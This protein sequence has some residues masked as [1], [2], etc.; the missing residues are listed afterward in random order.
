MT[1]DQIEDIYELSPLQQGFLFH[2]VYLPAEGAYFEQ[3]IWTL[4]GD[5]DIAAFEQAWQDAVA[6]HPILRSS[7]HWQ[8]L[9]NPVQ[10][11]H[12]EVTLPIERLDWRDLPPS[13][14][15]DRLEALLAADR[16]QGFDLEQPPLMRV[17]LAQLAARSWYFVWSYHHLLLDGWSMSVLL[18]DVFRSYDALSHGRTIALPPVRPYGDYIE[19]LQQRDPVATEAFWRQTLA[20]FAAP[21]PLI[22]GQPDA[23]ASDPAERYQEQQVRLSTTTTA[24]LQ[25]LARQQ[26][27]TLNTIFQGAWALLLG[28]YS[29]EHDIVF[30]ATASGRPSDLPGFES[31]VGLFI[32]TLPVRVQT[33]PDEALLPWLR[34]L[35]AVQFELRQYEYSPL[36]QVQSWSDVPHS[37][38]LFESIVVFENHPVDRALQTLSRDLDIDFVRC[39]QRTS[40]PLTVMAVPGSEL[41]IRLSYDTQRFDAATITRLLGHLETLLE[42]MTTHQEQ[43][44]GKLALVTPAEERALLAWNATQAAYPT[45]TPIHELFAAQAARTPD[46]IALIFEQERL[47]YRALNERANRLAHYLQALGVGGCPQGET[48]VAL[49]AERS[50]DSVIG[51]L[52]IFKA[53]GCYVPLDPAYPQERL[54]FMLDDT[55]APVLLTQAR[56]LSPESTRLPEHHARVVCLDR[57]WAEI[58]SYSADDPQIAVRG[59]DLAYM[60]YTSGTTGR[61]KAVM[62]EHRHL[63]NTMLAGQETCGFTAAT[64]MPCIASFAFDISLFE[65]W[66]PLLVGGTTVLVTR[67]RALDLP[68]FARILRGTTALHALPSLMREIVDFARQRAEPYAE[69]RQVLVGGDLVPVDLV[70]DMQACFPAAQIFIAYGPTEGTILCAMHVVPGEQQIQ[71]HLIGT[72]LPNTILRIYDPQ[73]NLVPIGVAGELY[74]GGA[75]VARGYLNRPELTAE[76]FVTLDGQRWYRTGDLVRYLPDGT[77]EFLGRIDQQVKLRGFRI[78]LGEI[79][80]ALRQHPGIREAAVIARED[81]P[82][83]KR[84]VAYVVPS[85]AQ[86][87]GGALWARVA[88]TSSSPSPM[89]WEQGPEGEGLHSELETRS[90][91]STARSDAIELWPSI[92]EY[93]IYDE[94]LYYGLTNDTRRIAGYKAA[95]ERT[96]RDKVVVEIGTGK[97]AIVAQHCVAAGARRVYALEILEEPYRA[98][99]ERI[100]ALGLDDRVIVIHGDATTIELPEPAD[101]CVSEIFEAIGGGEGASEILNRSRRLLKPGGTMIPARSL[102]KIAAVCLPE[103]LAA[104][105]RFTGV[106]GYYVEQIFE[107]VGH[108]F[109][110]RLCIKNFPRSQIIS[111]EGVFEDLDFSDYTASEYCHNLSLTIDRAGRFDG[112]LIWLNLHMIEGVVLDALDHDYAWFPVYFPIFDPGVAVEPGDRIELICSASLSANGIHPDYAVEGRLLRRDGTPLPFAYQSVHHEQ[113]Y[114]ATPFYQRLFREDTIP[115]QP[116][117]QRDDL[118]AGARDHLKARLPEYMVPSAFVLLDTLPLTANGKVDRKALPAPEAAHARATETAITPRTPIEHKIAQIWQEVLQ[119]DGVGVNENFFDLGGH[120]I[121]MMQVHSKL[122]ERLNRDIAMTDLFRHPTIAALAQFLNPEVDESAAQEQA[123]AP[124]P[125]RAPIAPIADTAIAIVGMSGRFPGARDV[126]RFWQNLCAGSESITFFTDDELLAAG[127]DPALLSHPDYVK[128]GAI[129]DD[130]ELFDAGFFGYSPREAAIMDP[131]H[132]VFLECAWEALERAGYNPDAYEGGIGVFAGVSTNSYLLFNLYANR[133]LLES[134]GG[135]QTMLLNEKDHL[136][137]RVSYKLNL[138][139]PSVNLQTACSTSLVATVI[140]CQ[141]L[142][143]RQCDMALAGGVSINVPHTAGYR[144]QPGGIQSPDGH[145]RAFDADAQGTITGNGVGIVV[146]KRLHDALADGDQIQAVIKGFALNNDG[147]QKVGYTAPSVDG[148]AA[149]IEEALAMAGVAPETISYIETHGTGTPLGDPIEIAALSRVFGPV[150]K[151][152]QRCALGSVKTNIGHLDA[153]AGV[154]GLIKTTLALHHSQIPASLHFERP[155]PMID[156]A[157]SPFYVNTNLAEWQ[158]NGTPRR[159]GVSSFGIGGT[160]AHIVLE[161][162][163]PIEPSGLSR[164]WHVLTLSARSSAALEQAVGNLASYLQQHPDLNLADVA[165]TLNVG[166]K[167]FSH[168]QMVVCRD[169]MDA[170]ETLAA[171]DPQRVSIQVQERQDRP[172]VFL[173]PGQGAQYVEMARELYQAEPIFREH[174]DRC[175]ALLKPHLDLDLRDVLYPAPDQLAAASGQLHRTWLTQPA[176]F[177][178]EYALARLWMAWGVRPQAL[179]GHSIGEYVAATVA[180]VFSLEDALAL[181]ALRGRLIESLPEGAM[182]SVPLS[183][184]ELRPL[185]GP[186]LAIAAVNAP[187][188]CV[189]AGPHTAI[190]RIEQRLVARGVDC[191]RL[192][193]SHAFHSPMMEPILA[194]FAEHMRMVA[195][196]RP[197][198]PYLSNLTGDWITPEQ[199]TDPDYWARHLRQPVRFADNVAAVLSDPDRVLLEVGPGRMLGTLARRHQASATVLASLR[200]PHDRESDVAFLLNSLG[201]LWAVGGR[202]DW[203]QLYTAERRRRVVLPTYPFERQRYWIDP[204]AQRAMSEQSSADLEERAAER[205]AALAALQPR[206]NLLNPYVAPGTTIEES[207]AEIWQELLGVGP[208]G[209]HDNFFDLGGHSLMATQVITRLRDRFPVDLPVADVFDAATVAQ[210]AAIIEAKLI[211]KLDDLTEEE[212]RLLM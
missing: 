66:T 135:F 30:G 161:E 17:A 47:S 22:A 26:Q 119:L 15:A 121:R 28:R 37:I 109:D 51:M 21:T 64:I 99:A 93:A 103:A 192:H 172:V 19:W 125:P 10:A 160:N 168:R 132:R 171:R 146:L 183:E 87:G 177:V 199:A 134:V 195:L 123:S 106:S 77:I 204:P 157:R 159:A 118:I 188:L 82:G 197:R 154:T 153:A 70:Q 80:A 5:L 124:H 42:A 151:E 79:E 100:R 46:A 62:V 143:L 13:S 122:Q 58:A 72:P 41:L 130:I 69:I 94:V 74:L 211:E 120:S 11:V 98:A 54:R 35:Q 45:E 3:F 44:L 25:A 60:I 155:N 116:D 2:T 141:Q 158:A 198:I 102:T 196:H 48:P 139:G 55:Q 29:G 1:P 9:D 104:D 50:I 20:G 18:A 6:R 185:L 175:A 108:P 88:P 194:Q 110:L 144:Y 52:A 8:D 152:A 200:H 81:L 112:F 89:Q 101:V 176:L 137:T 38:P 129:L 127:I 173:F 133:D 126:E 147:A 179:L 43:H 165:Y 131:Q 115:I 32:N 71:K 86:A 128:A 136:T 56:L 209:I 187:S 210:L 14:H 212:A 149:V 170:V 113:R 23:A 140:A 182:L 91:A 180:G 57:D 164:P 65:L 145:C 111:N 27:V 12:R 169:L 67:E 85:A 205:S 16:E 156:F 191:R 150:A 148:Q 114:R 33:P 31:M 181:V 178:I 92:G 162:A 76:R 90:R 167:T 174:V 97:D 96:V 117:A 207:I 163:P 78:E 105:P 36:V 73:Q 142:L 84:L 184:A 166:R 206:P 75:G 208:I 59:D 7:F 83:E 138:R 203:R 95:L 68:G 40:Y 49:C 61:P 189:V 4:H 186:D 34:R 107:H 53:G 201:Q 39:L 193:T 63:V 24:A 190:E 202:L